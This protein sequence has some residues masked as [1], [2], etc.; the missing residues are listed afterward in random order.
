MSIYIFWYFRF[1]HVG[2]SKNLVDRS[3]FLQTSLNTFVNQLTEQHFVSNLIASDKIKK[4]THK[5]RPFI[6]KLNFKFF[7]VLRNLCV[8]QKCFKLFIKFWMFSLTQ[9]DASFFDE[10]IYR[11]LLDIQVLYGKCF[12]ICWVINYH[13]F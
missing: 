8:T 13:I 9:I 12:A 1:I 5:V 3:I 4:D 7:F 6:Q 11:Y 2:F 10:E